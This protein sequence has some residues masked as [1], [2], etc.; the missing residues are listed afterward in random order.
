[1]TDYNLTLKK[2]VEETI[3][4]NP[5]FEACIDST[6]ES[7]LKSN[8]NGILFKDHYTHPE[9]VKICLA[10]FVSNASSLLK[11]ADPASGIFFRNVPLSIYSHRKEELL[12]QLC[13]LSGLCS[14]LL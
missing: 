3:G 2:L 8:V 12:S 1:M 4:L 7:M 5:L 14:P 11:A 10:E 13:Q 9:F 6:I